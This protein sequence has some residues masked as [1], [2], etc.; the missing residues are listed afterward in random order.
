MFTWTIAVEHTP[1]V[2][3][4]SSSNMKEMGKAKAMN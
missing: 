1:K 2:G 3:K 4:E